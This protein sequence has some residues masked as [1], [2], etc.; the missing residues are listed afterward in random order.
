MPW[1]QLPQ[2][3][4]E[5]DVAV[6]R[7]PLRIGY[8]RTMELFLTGRRVE[9][10]E[11]VTLG[12]VTGVLKEQSPDQVA[13][14]VARLIAA[15]PSLAVRATKHLVRARLAEAMAACFAEEIE[16]INRLL[17]SERRETGTNDHTSVVT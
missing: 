5:Q 16:T 14:E 7:A 2:G 6:A 9:A 11:A 13:L 1:L 17:L 3:S 8:G 4:V 12:L 10:E 15:K